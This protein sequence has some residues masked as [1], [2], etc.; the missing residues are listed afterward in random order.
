MLIDQQSAHERILYE[1]N[2]KNLS[3]HQRLTQKE[4]FPRTIELDNAKT[5]VLKE[6]LPKI[7][8]LGF[9]VEAF[10]QNS[11][12]VHGIPAG[13]PE[14]KD[15]V[16]LVEQMLDQ[17]TS[18]VDLDIG[19]EENVARSLAVSAAIK[20]GKRLAVP[21]MRLIIDRLFA[22]EMP[23]KSPTGRK[24]FI[25]KKIDDLTKEFL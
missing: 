12:L 4:L 1:D 17:Y 5:Q 21:E 10:G 14:G 8:A 16:T 25:S 23:F 13:L 11:Y 19:I 15:A 7:N 2:I 22:C 20:R 9:E 6:I 24:C 3:S 18:N